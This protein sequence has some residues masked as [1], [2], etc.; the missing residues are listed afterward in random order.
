MHS[1]TCRK[2]KISALKMEFVC[3]FTCLLNICRKFE[4]LISQGSVATCLRWGGD[5][6]VAFVAN[7]TSFPAVQKFWKSVKIWQSY[8]EL[9]DGKF[10]ETQCRLV[11]AQRS[12]STQDGTKQIRLSKTD[13]LEYDTRCLAVTGEDWSPG[14]WPLVVW[15]SLAVVVLVSAAD[16]FQK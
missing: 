13:L 14:I 3:I 12:Y 6:C 2:L 4:F 8:R 7:F 9:K 5:C 1:Y 11:D 10:F 15:Q 16:Y